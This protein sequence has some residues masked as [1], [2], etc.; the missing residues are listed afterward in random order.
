MENNK[1]FEYT[2]SAK[3][4]EE[5][6]KIKRKYL[7]KEESKLELLRKLDRQVTR[8]GEVVSLI[9]GVVGCLIMGGGMSMCMVWI[10][11]LLIPG[12]LLGILGAVTMGMAYPAYTRITQKERARLAPQIL[13]L[14]EEI[15]Q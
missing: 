13:A 9:L 14:T 2:Y 4:Q 12:I 15:G 7:P 8:K 10:D 6:E 5:I 3:E 11:S 1:A